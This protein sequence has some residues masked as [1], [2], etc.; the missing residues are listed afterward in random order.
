MALSSF[1]NGRTISNIVGNDGLHRADV[2]LISGKKRLA[3]NAIVTVEQLF[4]RPGFSAA[5]FAIGTFE[6]C[7]GV[8]AAGDDIRIE[9]AV[10]CDATLFPAVDL[11]Y[12]ITA[13]DVA[14]SQPEITVRDN[15]ITALNADADFIKSW[16][17]KDVQDNGIVVVE[18]IHR[19]EIGDRIV[20]GDFK[21]TP[22]GT[23]TTTIA[24]DTVERRGT[25]TELVRSIDDPRQGILGITGSISIAPGAI[26][27]RI[28]VDAMDGVI[29]DMSVNGSVTPADYR[30]EADP[31]FDQ[32]FTQIR[33]HG[34]DSGIR[35][36]R[37]LGRNSI[38][39]NGLEF[40]V[41]SD[42]L[43][44]E[45]DSIFSTDDIKSRFSSLSGFNL[46]VQSGNDHFLGIDD[47]GFIT[48]VVIRKQGTFATDDF[49]QVR[50]QDNLSQVSDLFL[51]ALGFKR[52]P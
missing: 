3:T 2:E 47:F 10:G 40:N 5:W 30:I 35:F 27:N 25:E 16:K 11:T 21:V 12:T 14:A 46:N 18:S 48:P 43:P 34:T 24:F 33:L 23:T 51:T 29:S 45:L 52:V 19:A 4:G 17:A 8:G 1:H 42:D 44:V 32:F 36:Q 50:V 49:I 7:D 31:V 39:T 37:F 13:P 38:L 41:K 15:I 28:T 20:A 9:I 6:D 26:S 22:T